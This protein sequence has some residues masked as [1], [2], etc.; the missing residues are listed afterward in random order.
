V[1]RTTEVKRSK[2]RQAGD[3]RERGDE[4]MG[5][6]REVKRKWRQGERKRD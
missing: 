2:K 4:E 6:G 1:K 3:D 5:A